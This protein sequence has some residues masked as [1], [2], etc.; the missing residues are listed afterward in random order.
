MFM[1]RFNKFHFIN[2]VP[3]RRAALSIGLALALSSL[4][5]MGGNFARATPLETPVC[6][7]HLQKADVTLVRAQERLET[8]IA[9]GLKAE[10]AAMHGQVRALLEVRNIYRRCFDDPQRSETVDRMNISIEET[11]DRISA[12]C[13]PRSADAGDARIN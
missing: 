1:A 9:E 5:G 4:P 3:V 11:T 10:C 2:P 6:R 12:R 8:A 7:V 13:S